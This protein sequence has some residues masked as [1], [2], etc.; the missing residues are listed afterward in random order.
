M[1][2]IVIDNYDSFVYNI[3]YLL[4]Q[5]HHTTVDVVK[6]DQVKLEDIKEY[7]KVVLS[8]GPGLPSRAGLMPQIL[9]TYA[10]SK[11]ILGVCLGHQAIAEM[12]S[13]SLR[14]LKHPLHGVASTV[15]ILKDDYLFQNVPKQFQIGHYHSWV[16][17]EQQYG[18]LEVIAQDPQQHIMAVRHPTFD[19]RGVQF[20]P[21]SV[22]TEY[23]QQII[24][25]WIMQ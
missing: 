21:E 14:N 22:L 2:T 3:V 6:N 11:S 13:G 10:H 25:N 18:Q 20:H 19:V 9:Q 12:F 24:H 7:D 15:Q 17:D 16:I 8:P 5:H 23:G 1:K 4:R